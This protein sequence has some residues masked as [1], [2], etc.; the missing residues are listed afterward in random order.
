MTDHRRGPS[1]S[2][3]RQ[4]EPEDGPALQRLYERDSAFFEETFGHPVGTEAVSAFHSAPDGTDPSGKLMLGAFDPAG[5]MRAFVDLW[6]R[7]PEPETWTV[8]SLF[9]APEDRGSGLAEELW[10]RVE[11]GVRAGGGT[12]VRVSPASEQKRAVAYFRRCG[13]SESATAVRHLG[14]RDLELLIMI[15]ELAPTPHG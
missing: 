9:V 13:L 11:H 10:S 5:E 3:W 2:T 6:P 4:V 7:W 12:R 15:K 14:L 8:A 1:G